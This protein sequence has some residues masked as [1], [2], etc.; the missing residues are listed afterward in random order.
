MT[1]EGRFV[2]F[3]VK[4]LFPFDCWELDK[5]LRIKVTALEEAD[6]GHGLLDFVLWV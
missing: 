1:F 3:I 2:I 6:L 5:Q 4:F